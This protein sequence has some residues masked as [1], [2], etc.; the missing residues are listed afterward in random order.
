MDEVANSYA[1]AFDELNILTAISYY[2]AINNNSAKGAIEQIVD[3]F[4]SFLVSAYTLG[5]SDAS[6]M[7]EHQIS[8]ELDEMEEAIYM[9]I[10]GKTFADRVAD[11]VEA[12][13]LTALQTLAKSEY[14]RVY[15]AA[16]V[17]G[18]EQYAQRINPNVIKTWCTR[19]DDRVRDTHDYLE[20][21]TVGLNERFFTYDGDSA[22]FPGGFAKAENN[23]GCR[24][25]VTLSKK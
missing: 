6:I 1:L 7:L 19:L 9:M 5:I 14:H 10:D 23:C 17:D 11:H 22:L 12:E 21:M 18:G 3:D 8:I 4:L 16:V 24:C 2:S 13:D 15:N 25:V 20:G